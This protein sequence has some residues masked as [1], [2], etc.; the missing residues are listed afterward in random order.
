M[1]LTSSDKRRFWAK[2][3]VSTGAQQ[4]W[5]WTASKTLDGYGMI[6]IN[7]RLQRAHRVSY[8]LHYGV[9]PDNLFV[10]HTCDNPS[11]VNPRHLYLGTAADNNRD[12]DSKN[13]FVPPIPRTGEHHHM[14]KLSAKDVDEIRFLYDSGSMNQ[15]EL[16]EKYGVRQPHISRIIHK[17]RWSDS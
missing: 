3:D 1:I 14:S 13:R 8:F 6:G 10:C 2:V 12:R 17:V 5:V 15:R 4:C 7:G 16:A 9:N 11:C